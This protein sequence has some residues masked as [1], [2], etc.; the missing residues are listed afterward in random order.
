MTLSRP[1]PLWLAGWLGLCGLPGC[2]PLAA[3]GWSGYAEGDYVLVAAPVAGTL[4]VLAVQAGQVVVQGASL[5]TLEAE[6]DIAALGEPL[7][8]HTGSVSSVAFSP[9]GARIASGSGDNTRFCRNSAKR[10]SMAARPTPIRKPESRTGSLQ[11]RL[12]L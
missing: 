1:G 2:T 10:P 4:K 3:S 12:G 5:F 6:A 11:T 9:D 7:R 8:G